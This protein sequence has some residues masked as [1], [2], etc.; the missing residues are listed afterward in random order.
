MAIRGGGG[1]L[2]GLRINGGFFLQLPST[3]QSTGGLYALLFAF[4]LKYLEATHTWKFLTLQT[5]FWMPLW[6][7]NSFTPSQSTLKNRSKNRPCLRG[8]K[9]LK[10]CPLFWIKVT[11]SQA[12]SWTWKYCSGRSRMYWTLP[13]SGSS[14]RN[15]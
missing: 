11:S 2:N 12:R 9:T 5:L 15:F 8:L 3:P 14:A 4:Y 7:K 1:G 10:F 13:H 6:K